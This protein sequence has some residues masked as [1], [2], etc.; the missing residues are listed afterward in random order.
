[1]ASV[2]SV[3]L[4]ALGVSPADTERGPVLVQPDGSHLVG[5]AAMAAMLALSP[6]PYCAVGRVMA[7]PGLRTV[8][9]AVGV[10]LYQQ[11]WRLPGAGA[12][13]AAPSHAA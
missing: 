4:D 3:D 7:A 9:N 13:C 6:R 10:R 11:R 8:L 2:Q 5:T 12:A 1:M